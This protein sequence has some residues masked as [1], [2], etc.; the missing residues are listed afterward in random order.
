MADNPTDKLRIAFM[1]TPDFSTPVLDA[2][3]AAGHDVACVYSQPPRAAGRGQKE[4]LTPVHARAQALGIEVRTPKSLKSAE[5]QVAFAALDLDCAVV[6]AYG[7]ILPKE[8]LDAPRLGCLNIHASLL[9][10]WRGAAPIQRAILAGDAMSGVTIMQMDEGLDTGAMLLVDQVAITHETTGESLHDALSEMGARL[11]VETLDA[12]AANT[13][14][15]IAQPESGVTYASKLERAEGH[16][17]WQKSAVE[18]ERLVRAFTPWP[19]SWFEV[20]KE[21]IKI[22]SA[23]LGEGSG[24]PSTVLDDQL[25]VACAEGALRLLKVQRAG[26]GPVAAADFLRGFE[27]PPGSRLD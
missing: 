23:E 11:I 8:I 13:V 2:L 21:R 14:E 4:T 1:G 3:I 7:L 22:L 15:A 5:E 16:I 10:R 24:A 20:G 9:P 25:T 6:V 19:G 27:L 18:L 26:K 12:R 17:D